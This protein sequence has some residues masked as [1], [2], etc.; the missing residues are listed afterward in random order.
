MDGVLSGGKILFDSR[1]AESL[2]FPVVAFLRMS[3]L[4]KETIEK[5][6]S[7]A[8]SR[9]IKRIGH[10]MR[11]ADAMA[12]WIRDK[13]FLNATGEPRP[14]KLK[15]KTGFA[16]LVR[17]VSPGSDPLEMLTALKRFGNVRTLRDGT[18]K[19]INPF[20]IFLTPKSIALEPTAYFLEDASATISRI[21]TW[22]KRSGGPDVFWRK[23]ENAN[24]TTASARKFLDFTRQRTLT[25]L[26]ELN[27]WLEAHC[28]TRV[29]NAKL[30][31]HRVGL[32]LFYIHSKPEPYKCP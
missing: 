15:G 18:Y 23:V 8:Y 21:L 28:E 4:T 31:R 2:L 25:F 17:A 30:P 11:Y 27:D 6:L 24:L 12:T 29:N 13:R 7:L 20:F 9:R 26:E 5:S 1:R 14:L 22:R 10:P 19:L 32:G 3:G 16:A